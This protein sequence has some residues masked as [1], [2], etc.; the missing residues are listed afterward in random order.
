MV[1][2]HSTCFPVCSQFCVIFSQRLEKQ[3]ENLI[4]SSLRLIGFFTHQL[5]THII[6]VSS[7]VP[8][9]RTVILY[10]YGCACT[11]AGA[12]TSIPGSFFQAR[13]IKLML[14]IDQGEKDDKIIAVCADDPEFRHYME[15]NECPPHR[16]AGIRCFLL[17]LRASIRLLQ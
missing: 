7:P 16:L 10:P 3:V 6:L 1:M 8:F 17:R 2:C 4:S 13:A 15:L 11:D 9:A 5:F 14:M 12:Y